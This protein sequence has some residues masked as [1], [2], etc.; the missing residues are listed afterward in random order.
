MATCTYEI[1]KNT[2]IRE[3]IVDENV[4]YTHRMEKIIGL[5]GGTFHVVYL[6]ADSSLVCKQL[7]CCEFF[8]FI[9]IN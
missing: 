7:L 4:S 9:K 5:V 8:L 2:H 1:E 6:F 3:I